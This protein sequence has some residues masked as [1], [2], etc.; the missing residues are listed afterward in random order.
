MPDHAKRTARSKT[1]RVADPNSPVRGHVS[2]ERDLISAVT[3][4][5]PSLLAKSELRPMINRARSYGRAVR[6]NGLLWAV[7]LRRLQDAGA[8]LTYGRASFGTWAATEFADLDLSA[9]NAKKLS[10]AGRVM[11]LL[12]EHKCVNLEDPRTFPGTTGARVL[13]S[14]L[15]AHGEQALLATFDRCPDGNV[16][17]GTVK[18][19]AAA[20]LPAP[21]SVTPEVDAGEHGDDGEESYELPA[22]VQEPRG[23][24]ERLRDYLDELAF[25]DDGDPVA[26][27]REYQHFVEDAQ[28]LKAVLE[29]V[30]PEESHTQ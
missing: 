19:A 21:A 15:A 29:A 2:P 12:A 10:H 5:L 16:V 30:L 6:R 14:V 11:L 8:H 1:P 20:L 28:G 27:A 22:E 9:D 17:S 18:Q 13:A 26:I 4:V 25:A 24:V 3:E 7:Q 23:R